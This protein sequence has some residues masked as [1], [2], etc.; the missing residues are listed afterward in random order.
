MVSLAAVLFARDRERAPNGAT[1]P[2][3]QSGAPLVGVRVHFFSTTTK[4]LRV[5]PALADCQPAVMQA[6]STGELAE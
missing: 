6:I 1:M 5:Q 3:Y 4:K 2:A